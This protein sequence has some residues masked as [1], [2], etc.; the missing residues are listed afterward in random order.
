ME[1]RLLVSGKRPMAFL[2]IVPDLSWKESK[3]LCSKVAQRFYSRET[4]TGMPSKDLAALGSSGGPVVCAKPIPV[5][6][7]WILQHLPLEG[8]QMRDMCFVFGCE[9]TTSSQYN[10]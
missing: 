2:A 4:S 5:F 8:Y 9:A 6:W 10:L 7:N 3:G 1:S